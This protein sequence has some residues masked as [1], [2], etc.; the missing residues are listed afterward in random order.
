[1]SMDK[2]ILGDGVFYTTDT[3]VTGI[4]NNILVCGT[5]GCGK[6]MS[7]SE[8]R[9][10]ETYN[11]SL[12]ITVT[13]RRIAEMYKNTFEER[14]YIVEELNFV[15][16]D[17]STVTYDPL[18]FVE[19]TT[20]ITFLAT[21]IAG[22]DPNSDQTRYDPYWTEAA[23]SLFSAEIAY[24]LETE[25]DPTFDDVLNLHYELSFLP[26]HRDD[27]VL[28]T[29]DPKFQAL[30]AEKPHCFAVECWST[31]HNV[32]LVTASCI[33]GNL[34]T[35]L[36]KIFTPALRRMFTN[37]RAVDF[38]Q[39]SNK[40]TVL[41]LTTS[42]VNP[43]LNCFVNLFYSQT[44]KSLFEYAE[45]LPSKELPIPV[46]VLCDDFATGS[47]I[48]NFPEYIS[49][50]REKGISVTLLL[51]SESQLI[52]MY[53]YNDAT[54]I[55]NNCDTYIYM[56]GSDLK[57]SE[58]VSQRLDK[59]LSDVLYMPVGQIVVFRRGQNPIVTQRYNILEDKRYQKISKEYQDGINE[60]KSQH[61]SRAS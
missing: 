56:G 36:D 12:I 18:C 3:K 31:F 16:P 4:N 23:I 11:S 33:Y 6:T 35:K 52:S 32:P 44:F 14:G 59:P 48:N 28:T 55:I 46:H 61:K 60:R 30:R 47:R 10:L 54:T 5:S 40:K 13:K 41:I 57:T 50:F 27:R 19:N 39:L 53:G 58:S 15:D 37:K 20:D 22:N 2:V 8:P 9:L 26:G 51:Q 24:I 49:I 17:S 29:I 38:E 1:M 34:N 43:S 21:A 45:Q 42:A 25:E 7:I